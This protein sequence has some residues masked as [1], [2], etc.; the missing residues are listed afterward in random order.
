MWWMAGGWSR[1]ESGKTALK[2]KAFMNLAPT[3]ASQ[4]PSLFVADLIVPKLTFSAGASE[5]L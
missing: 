3:R 5:R 1:M 2:E 4:A